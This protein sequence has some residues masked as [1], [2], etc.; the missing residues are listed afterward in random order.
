MSFRAITLN[1]LWIFVYLWPENM[2][3]HRWNIFL[4]W[5]CIEGA[6]MSTCKE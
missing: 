5:L 1:F 6:V 3:G 2:S 4:L